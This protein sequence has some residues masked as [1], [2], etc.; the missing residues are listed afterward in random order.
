MGATP[1]PPPLGS[2]VQRELSAQL[3]EGLSVRF[4]PKKS[5]VK[6][7]PISSTIFL[8]PPSRSARHLPFV[9]KGR[10]EVR[11]ASPL[12]S[13][14]KRKGDKVLRRIFAFRS[15]NQKGYRQNAKIQARRE[16]QGFPSGS[17]L[18]RT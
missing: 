6:S 2:L 14:A 8:S 13:G 5:L 18:K 1:H 3:T 16:G 4:F 9:K 11:D 12:H 10:H 15:I 17:V 7:L